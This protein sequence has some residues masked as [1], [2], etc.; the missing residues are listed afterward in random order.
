MHAFALGFHER[1]QDNARVGEREREAEREA[2]RDRQ[3]DRERHGARA[4]WQIMK[5]WR[6]SVTGASL[7]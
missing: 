1:E 7:R 5:Y 4:R 2:E 6:Y 3:T